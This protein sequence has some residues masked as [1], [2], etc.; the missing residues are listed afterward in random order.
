MF[1]HL[2]LIFTS[3]LRLVYWSTLKIANDLPIFASYYAFV[4]RFFNLFSV[5]LWWRANARNVRFSI[6]IGS[7]PTFLYFDLYLYSAYAAHYV[8]FQLYYLSTNYFIKG[9]EN[10]SSCFSQ[11]IKIAEEVW[12]HNGKTANV[13]F[14]FNMQ[15]DLIFYTTYT[16]SFFSPSPETSPYFLLRPCRILSWNL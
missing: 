8:Y 5:S 4:T 2:P 9:I 12:E 14:S 15:I 13:F 16:Y 11:A 10:I 6:G 1:I 7:T 3:R